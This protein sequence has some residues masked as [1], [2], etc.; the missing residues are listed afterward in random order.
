MTETGD[1]TRDLRHRLHPGGADRAERNTRRFG[2]ICLTAGIT[3]PLLTF[4]AGLASAVATDNNAFQ[5]EA[6]R[7][8]AVLAMVA[9]IGLGCML[10]VIGGVERLIRGM[11]DGIERNRILVERVAVDVDEKYRNLFGLVAPLPHLVNDLVE[12]VEKVPRYPEAVLD[13]F[14]LARGLASDSPEQK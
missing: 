14:D 1:N 3:L 4:V 6:A 5:D 8:F 10:V 2:F 7:L 11:R 13:G 12:V 9:T